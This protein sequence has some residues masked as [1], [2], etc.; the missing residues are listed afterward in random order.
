MVDLNLLPQ[1]EFEIIV[2]GEVIPG[3][4]GVWAIKRF[5][6]KKGMT[7]SDFSKYMENDSISWDDLCVFILAAIEYGCRKKSMPFHYDDL[8]LCE[9]IEEMGGLLSEKF[10]ALERHARD[11]KPQ[12]VEK[13]TETKSSG[14]NSK[15][16]FIAQD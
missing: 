2:N 4:Y 10:L 9:V 5:S 1:K 15:K 8:W 7:F 3:K 13:K 16:S 12:K 6:D 14:G 11:E